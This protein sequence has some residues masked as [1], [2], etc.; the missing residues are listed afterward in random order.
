MF[1]IRICRRVSHNAKVN[2]YG[3][4]YIR[5]MPKITGISGSDLIVKCPV[6][7]YPID[8]IHWERGKQLHF[9]TILSI[10]IFTYMM[11]VFAC[12]S[13]NCH[14]YLHT[15]TH[16]H[17][18]LASYVLFSAYLFFSGFCLSFALIVVCFASRP[19]F[20]IK[21]SPSPSFSFFSCLFLHIS[22]N[23]IT[24]TTKRTGRLAL[25]PFFICSVKINLNFS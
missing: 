6:A 24:V 17:I 16:T 9:L 1:F 21:I 5:E 10:Y 11:Y 7:G 22:M 14:M 20:V 2:I 15:H 18:S 13:Y 4:P 25:L 8:K 3:L 23:I 12:Y 19:V